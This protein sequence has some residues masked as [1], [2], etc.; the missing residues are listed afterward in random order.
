MASAE[1]SSLRE[2]GKGATESPPLRPSS[3]IQHGI[4]TELGLP[5][6]KDIGEDLFREIDDYTS[7]ELEAERVRVRKLI[8]WRIMPIVSALDGPV[9]LF[10][11]I[12]HRSASRTPFNFSTSSH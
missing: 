2:D 6:S 8:D 9:R 7:E 5:V 1:K 11:L 4:A 3:S 10:L 12:E